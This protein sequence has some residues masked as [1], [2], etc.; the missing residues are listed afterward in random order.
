MQVSAGT[1]LSQTYGDD[2]AVLLLL[3]YKIRSQ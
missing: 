3:K 1:L 2:G